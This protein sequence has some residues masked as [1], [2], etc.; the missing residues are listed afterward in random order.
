M[1]EKPLTLSIESA[2][3]ILEVESTAPSGAQVLWVICVDT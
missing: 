1:V 2:L 3:E